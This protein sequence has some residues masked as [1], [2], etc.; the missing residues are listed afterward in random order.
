MLTLAGLGLTIASIVTLNPLLAIA[1]GALL[2]SGVSGFITDVAASSDNSSDTGTWLFQLGLGAV[3]GA[4]FGAASIGLGLGIR[5]GSKALLSVASR[6]IF[7]HAILKNSFSLLAEAGL[8]A[9]AGATQQVLTNAYAG[10]PL[11]KDVGWSA[12]LGAIAGFLAVGGLKGKPI[13]SL[14]CCQY[15]NL[16]SSR[17]KQMDSHGTGGTS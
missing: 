12:A 16:S 2:N 7:K 13:Y 9:A 3:I 8:G 11:G 4:V 17:A 10:D 14:Y 15:P 6:Q 1:G 5:H